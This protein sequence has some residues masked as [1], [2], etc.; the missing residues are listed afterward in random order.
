MKHFVLIDAAEIQ[1]VQNFVKG[2][3]NKVLKDSNLPTAIFIT[4]DFCKNIIEKFLNYTDLET[5]LGKD[6]AKLIAEAI[7]LKYMPNFSLEEITDEC[8]RISEDEFCLDHLFI[9]EVSNITVKNKKFN[10]KDEE[11]IYITD[12][13]A[14]LSD[15]LDMTTI[16]FKNLEEIK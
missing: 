14:Q 11:L 10:N 16:I 12:K 8:L 15:K 5:D 1:D 2:L 13:L 7:Y 9:D 4:S 6:S 3:L